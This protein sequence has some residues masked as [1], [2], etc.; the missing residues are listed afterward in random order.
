MVQLTNGLIIYAWYKLKMIISIIFVCCNMVSPMQNWW[1]LKFQVNGSLSGVGTFAIQI[2]KYYEASV[3]V[4]T[5][6]ISLFF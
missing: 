5:S 1:I 3:F 2:A 6:P 4:T